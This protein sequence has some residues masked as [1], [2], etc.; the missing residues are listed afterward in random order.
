MSEN[1]SNEKKEIQLR[2]SE[3]TLITYTNSMSVIK[4]NKEDAEI[5]IGVLDPSNSFIDVKQRLFMSVEHLKRFSNML[6][7]TIKV[8]DNTSKK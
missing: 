3:N 4:I 2:I 6:N 1:I 8:I 5:A 7:E